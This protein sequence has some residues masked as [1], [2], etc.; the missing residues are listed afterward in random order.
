[1][2]DWIDNKVTDPFGNSVDL[3]NKSLLQKLVHRHPTERN[4]DLGLNGA[5]LF[6]Q[7]RFT[8]TNLINHRIAILGGTIQKLPRFPDERSPLPILIKARRLSDEG[9]LGGRTT[10]P[11]N[12]ARSRPVEPTL[13]AGSDGTIDLFEQIGLFH[14]RSAH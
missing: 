1:M 12:G 13:A 5:E 11:G 8:R 14:S 2:K 6:L 10:L 9:D 7:V 4:N 3:G